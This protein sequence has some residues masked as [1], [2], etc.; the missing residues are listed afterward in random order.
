MTPGQYGKILA[1][2]AAQINTQIGGNPNLTPEKADTYTVGFVLQPVA[3]PALSVSVDY[4]DI[5]IQDTI[6]SLTSNTVIQNCALTGDAQLC[7]LIH[8]GV[9]T[10]SLW[11]NN[12]DYVDVQKVNIGTV[13]TKGIDLAAHYT[14]PIGSVGKLVF[15]LSGTHVN[16]FDT[17]PLPTGGSF[18]CTGL[19]GA[20]CG[21]PTPKWRHTF[22]TDWLTPWMTGLSFAA[23]WRYIGPVDVDSSSSNPQLNAAYQ[24]GSA[25]S[26]GT[27]T[28]TCRRRSRGSAHELPDRCQQRHRQA[29]ANR[30]E[31]QPVELPEH[32][33]QRQH[34]GGHLRHAGPLRVRAHQC[35][36]LIEAPRFVQ[37]N[38]GGLRPAAFF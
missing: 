22:E 38:C 28:S 7:G 33:L 37:T 27:T 3:L 31:R 26:V 21:A 18:D 19:Y 36:V 25:T 16:S 23:R 30:A 14:Q 2:P 17:Q 6:T 15:T 12:A 34:L 8:R 32:E 24:P 10:E 4:Y 1:N 5:K 29:T 9:G 20:T 13:A 35:E 11:F